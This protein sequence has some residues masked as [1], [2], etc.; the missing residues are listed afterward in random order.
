MSLSRFSHRTLVFSVSLSLYPPMSTHTPFP[1]PPRKGCVPP[2]CSYFR[3]LPPP[4]AHRVL[5]LSVHYWVI[6][7]FGS[8]VPLFVAIVG[9]GF[10]NSLLNMPQNDADDNNNGIASG[11]PNTGSPGVVYRYLRVPRPSEQGRCEP[12]FCYR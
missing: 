7:L 1:A 6:S 9:C 10:M 11:V 4:S 12:R 2:S 3:R 5:F 8:V